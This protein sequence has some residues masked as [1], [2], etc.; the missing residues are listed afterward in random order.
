VL[1]C[2]HVIFSSF[3]VKYV[4]IVSKIYGLFQSTLLSYPIHIKIMYLSVH[5]HRHTVTPRLS[6]KK[7][8][9]K[10]DVQNIL[11]GPQTTWIRHCFFQCSHSHLI[12]ECVAVHML[13]SRS[14]A[15]F[16]VFQ[17]IIM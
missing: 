13:C 5:K 8:I 16:V 14:S 15:C 6:I 1:L 10:K 3:V 11:P 17:L 7:D 9:E 4:G 12:S 2:S